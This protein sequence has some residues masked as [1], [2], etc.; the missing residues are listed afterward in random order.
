MRVS[1]ARLFKNARIFTGV[2]GDDELHNAMLVKDGKIVYV[3]TLSGAEEKSGVSPP[4]PWLI[5]S[6]KLTQRS[7]WSGSPT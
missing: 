4:H 3:G 7:T 2:E 5:C 6:T 1:I